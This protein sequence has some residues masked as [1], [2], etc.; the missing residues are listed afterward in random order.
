[1]A[2]AGFEVGI[3]VDTVVDIEVGLGFDS[4]GTLKE[5]LTIL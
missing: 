3:G 4:F 5:I 2:V 1:M